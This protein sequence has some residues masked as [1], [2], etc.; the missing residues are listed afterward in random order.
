V[1]ASLNAAVDAGTSD[2]QAII[3]KMKQTPIEDDLFGPVVVRPDG[4]AIHNM[5]ILKAK[6][7]SA[8]ESKW[9]L[10]EQ[11]GVLTGPQAFRPLDEGGCALAEQSRNN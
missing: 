11:V 9:D 7:P 4:R 2:S 6:S 10:L 5:Y 3:R 8:S 1:R